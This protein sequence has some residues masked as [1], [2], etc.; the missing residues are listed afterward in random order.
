MEELHNRQCMGVY[1]EVGL[2]SKFSHS[3][4]LGVNFDFW[5]SRNFVALAVGVPVCLAFQKL[6]RRRRF[7]FSLQNWK[8]EGFFVVRADV[9]HCGRGRLIQSVLASTPNWRTARSR[10]NCRFWNFAHLSNSKSIAFQ[11]FFW[12]EFFLHQKK[13]SRRALLEDRL[14]GMMESLIL[15]FLLDPHFCNRSLLV[16]FYLKLVFEW[17]VAALVTK[18]HVFNC[19]TKYVL[20]STCWYFLQIFKCAMLYSYTDFVKDLNPNCINHRYICICL[21]QRERWVFPQP[22]LDYFT[23]VDIVF[24]YFQNGKKWAYWKQGKF[25][26]YGH[27]LRILK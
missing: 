12:R 17:Q 1:K 26:N 3:D 27:V 25:Q 16:N 7:T 18:K 15:K 21:P 6:H 10:T 20:C 9:G 5:R 24:F 8:K 11:T 23:P 19:D 13:N 4:I 14:S 2:Q 22:Y